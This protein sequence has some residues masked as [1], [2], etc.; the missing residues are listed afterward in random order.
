MFYAHNEN[1]SFVNLTEAVVIFFL[2]TKIF[3]LM[4]KKC[5]YFVKKYTN[6]FKVQG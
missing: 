4:Q 2:S 3:K 6:T 1:T 5:L